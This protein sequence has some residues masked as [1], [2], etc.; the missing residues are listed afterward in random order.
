MHVVYIYIFIFI[1]T[2]NH[3]SIPGVEPE[4]YGS[5]SHETFR[6]PA[7]VMAQVWC[8]PGLPGGATD[9]SRQFRDA[10]QP[11]VAKMAV[12]AV[13]FRKIITSDMLVFM[14][15]VPIWHCPFG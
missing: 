6:N 3:I 1:F 7:G 2:M 5:M 4:T 13:W 11:V 14:D 12:V 8:S 10:W 15:D 9:W